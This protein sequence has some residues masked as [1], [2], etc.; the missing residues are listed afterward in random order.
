MKVAHPRFPRNLVK[1]NARPCNSHE[2]RAGGRVCSPHKA[3]KVNKVESLKGGQGMRSARFNA[4]ELH[5]DDE[6]LRRV[7]IRCR[8]RQRMQTRPTSTRI[9]ARGDPDGKLRFVWK[10]IHTYSCEFFPV[11]VFSISSIDAGINH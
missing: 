9:R 6:K 3:L 7:S 5:C 10:G 1:D 2:C 4:P 11:Y 8:R